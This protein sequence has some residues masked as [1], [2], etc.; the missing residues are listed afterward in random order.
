MPRTVSPGLSSRQVHGHVGLRARVR[1]HVGVLGA[2][3]GLGACDG[4]RLGHVHELAAAVVAPARVA[5]GVLVRHHRAHRLEHGV[6]DEV[7]RR[8]QLEATVL[9]VDLVGDRLGDLRGRCRSACAARRQGT[10]TC[11]LMGALID[12]RP[13]GPVM[14]AA[15]RTGSRVPGARQPRATLRHLVSVPLER[16]DLADAALVAPARERRR[17]GTPARWPIARS[18][19][20]RPRAQRED[21]GVVVLAASRAVSTSVTGR[22]PD[23]GDLVGRHR[24]ADARAADQDAAVELARRPRSRATVSAKS[25]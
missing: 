20:V 18:T 1:L 5:L 21:V 22:G 25:G 13:A 2:E 6:A 8:D 7:L 23:A 12:S 11:A 16:G 4:E 15:T 17:R 24:H 9:A 3:Q 19:G 10:V 14:P